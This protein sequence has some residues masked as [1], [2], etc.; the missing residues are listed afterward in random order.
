[1]PPD[2]FLIMIPIRLLFADTSRSCWHRSINFIVILEH[3]ERAGITSAESYDFE[4]KKKQFMIRIL[5]FP[6]LDEGG[7]HRL[8]RL[9]R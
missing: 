6:M 8:E 5:A 3:I 4:Q 2:E 1:M 7:L 9:N